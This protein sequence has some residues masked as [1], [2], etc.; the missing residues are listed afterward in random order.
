[1]AGE[2]QEQ[3]KEQVQESKAETIDIEAIKAEAR[4]QA[5]KEIAGLNRKVSEY[6]KKVKDIELSKLDETERAKREAA[7]AIAERDQIIAE[8]KLIKL[9][10]YRDKTLAGMGIPMEFAKHIKGS[11]ED[12]IT[13]NA[14]ELKTLF[15]KT[16]EDRVKSTTNQLLSGTSPKASD[17]PLGKTMKRDQFTVMNGMEQRDFIRS[18]GKVVD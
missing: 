7:D 18:G 14:K 8:T 13:L 11:S 12:E 17:A 10:A 5:A 3:A 4:A 15:D 1:M 16:V 9:E 6:E 2:T